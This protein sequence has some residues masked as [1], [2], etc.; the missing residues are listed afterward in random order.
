MPKVG[1][2]QGERFLGT[3]RQTGA[4]F[5]APLALPE[6]GCVDCIPGP[7]AGRIAVGPAQERRPSGVSLYGAVARMPGSNPP[8]RLASDLHSN[9]VDTEEDVDV[10]GI[11]VDLVAR[12]VFTDKAFLDKNG[13]FVRFSST[14][15][16]KV[17]LTA[18]NG[19]SV[20]ISN[21]GQFTDVAPIIDEVARTITFVT[22]F[23]GPGE[24]QDT[25]RARTPAGRGHRDL[26]GHL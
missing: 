6:E 21:A 16:V 7:A 17:T 11:T 10:C 18:A 19:K 23:I 14:A 24:D 22:S 15:S 25:A 2:S 5:I 4:V 1:P 26:R 20:I 13:D 12:G 3:S 8:P 9:F